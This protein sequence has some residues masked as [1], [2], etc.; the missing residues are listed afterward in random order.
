MASVI[1]VG[2]SVAYSFGSAFGIMLWVAAIVGFIRWRK[3]KGAT[4]THQPSSAPA[5]ARPVPMAE[6]GNDNQLPHA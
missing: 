1:V 5:G 3:R 6:R 4:I 2:S